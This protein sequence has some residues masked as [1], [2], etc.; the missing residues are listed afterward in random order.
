V[1][2]LS[3]WGVQGLF[4]ESRLFGLES[5]VQILVLRVL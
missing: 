3:R 5:M 4:L 1:S 2:T